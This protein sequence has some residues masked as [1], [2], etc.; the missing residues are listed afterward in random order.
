MKDMPFETNACSLFNLYVKI[1]YLSLKSFLDRTHFSVAHNIIQVF[2]I[3]RS[4]SNASICGW[5][6]LHLAGL[7]FMEEPYL[8]CKTNPVKIN[9]WTPTNTRNMGS[10]HIL[11]NMAQNSFTEQ[12]SKLVQLSSDKINSPRPAASK[13]VS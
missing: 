7:L 8:I 4:I 2:S 13:S 10:R 1:L 3:H 6:V 5:A 11:L 12:V 9:I